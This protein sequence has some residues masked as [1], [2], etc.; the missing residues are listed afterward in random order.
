MIGRFRKEVVVYKLFSA[1]VT[2]DVIAEGVVV[3]GEPIS[4]KRNPHG[5]KSFNTDLLCGVWYCDF[6]LLYEK[7]RLDAGE[8]VGLLNEGRSGRLNLDA[9]VLAGS[10]NW[11]HSLC[12]MW[13]DIVS[14]S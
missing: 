4:K 7:L 14:V 1:V 9:N 2:Q 8:K 6:G 10:H 3:A 13:E 12:F 11:D 5:A